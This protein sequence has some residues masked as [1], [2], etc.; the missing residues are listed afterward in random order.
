M[1]I[2]RSHR[3]YKSYG[4]HKSMDHKINKLHEFIHQMSVQV[5]PHNS[6][7]KNR[8]GTDSRVMQ[9]NPWTRR[10]MFKSCKLICYELGLNLTYF[11]TI[12]F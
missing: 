2:H 5:D 9:V 3:L 6:P 1:K 8:I 7:N 4:S 10:V 11:D 12:C